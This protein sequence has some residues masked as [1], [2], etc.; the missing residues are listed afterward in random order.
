MI[1]PGALFG[2]G[3]HP[4]T[5]LCLELLLDAEPGGALC[6]WGAGTG[7]LAVAAAR[8]GWAPVTAVEV[9]PDG[10]EAIRAN[11]AANGVEVRDGGPTSPRRRRR[12]ADGGGEPAAGAA[13]RRGRWSGRRSGCSPPG[14]WPA[15]RTRSRAAYG[16]A[17]VERRVL[18]EWAAVVLERA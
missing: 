11:A 16:M 14:S 10:L 8:L 4:T 9:M 12:G 7:V 2:A 1:D 18:G 5:Q 3:A 6:D 15:G 13:A 17:E